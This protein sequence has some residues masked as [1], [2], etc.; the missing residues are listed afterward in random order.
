[1]VSERRKSAWQMWWPFGLLCVL[2]GSRWMFSDALPGS[3]TTFASAS[4]GCGSVA[5][6]W[7][8]IVRPA[9]PARG[10][11]SPLQRPALGG[12]LLI[13][14]P[15][16][17]L[18][19]PGLVSGASF[20]V[21]LALTPVVLAV[22]EAAR[23]SGEP[24]AGRLWPGLAA[25][26]GLLLLLAQPSL[27]NPGADLLLALA[28]LL[29]GCGA[30]L[31]GSADENSWRLPAALLGGS[32]ALAIAAGVNYAM[33]TGG[34]HE[35]TGLASGLDAAE[36]LL[37]LL[38]LSRL[39]AARW[40]AQFALVPL[41]VVLQSIALLRGGLTARVIA[42]LFLLAAASAALLVPPSAEVRLDLGASRPDPARTD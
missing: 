10:S 4:L 11:R 17:G 14:G 27:A 13:A 26:A 15:L 16:I 8:L 40:S 22:A 33:H 29:T 25:I 39:S 18:V 1:M 9:P 31:F 36:A 12:A 24:L 30:V 38:A 35:M 42:G 32:V 28:P 7:L 6:L 21:A 37:S 2:Q 5:A 34:W 41:I 23:H 20:T 3:G 19:R